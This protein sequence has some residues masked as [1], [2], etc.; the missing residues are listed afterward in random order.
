[1]ESKKSPNLKVWTPKKSP[2]LKVWTP[3]NKTFGEST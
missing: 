2:N 3:K 1:M